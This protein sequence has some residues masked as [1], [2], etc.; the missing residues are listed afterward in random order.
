MTFK[1]PDGQKVELTIAGYQFPD[2]K[3]GEL[4]SNRLQIAMKISGHRWN[5]ET[6]DC[7]LT[8]FEVKDLIKWFR[9]LSGNKGLQYTN[10]FFEESNLAFELIGSNTTVKTIQIRFGAAGRPVSMNEEGDYFINF[11]FT[12]E[13]LANLAD[14][15]KTEYL[16]FPERSGSRWWRFW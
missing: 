2:N 5:W 13:E 10:M 11:N 6:V 12:N 16:R 3:E 9:N 8:T 15:L 1:S 14:E 4:D 7:C